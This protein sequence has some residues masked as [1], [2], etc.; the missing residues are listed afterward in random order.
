MKIK[1]V[2]QYLESIAPPG[3]QES[4]DNAGL[5]VGDPEMEIKG[6]LVC[7]DSTEAVVEEAIQ[8]KCNLIVAHH[9]IV[10]KGLKKINGKNYVERV[11]IKAI[12]KNIAIYAIHTNLDNV[13]YNGVNTRIAE[14]LGLINTE[15]LAPKQ[16]LKKLT[17]LVPPEHSAIVRTALFAAGAGKRDD[18]EH[19]GYSTLGLS[20]QDDQSE[21]AVKVEL[22]FAAGYERQ[23]IQALE[24]SHPYLNPRFDIIAVDNN[25]SEVG[26]GMIGELEEPIA[27]SVFLNFVKKSMNT[28]CIRHTKLKNRKVRKVALCGGSGSFLLRAAIAQRADVFITADFKYHE[29]FDADGQIVIADIGHFESEQFTINLLHEIIS[30]K[31]SNFAAYC[32]EVNTNPV[33]YLR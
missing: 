3:Y 30:N 4:Y 15:I 2:I 13:Y 20:T 14:N 22:L 32:T 26:S 9:P 23:I 11:V 16:M 27:E 25:H 17:T 21:A 18:M 33:K 10:F 7:L 19:L 31:F 6:V 28:S 29:F 5:I 8:K 1:K 12:Q 24:E